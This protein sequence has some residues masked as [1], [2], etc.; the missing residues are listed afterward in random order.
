M[1]YIFL[2]CLYVFFRVLIN[3]KNDYFNKKKGWKCYDKGHDKIIYAEY[4]NG[5]WHSM[6][7][8]AQIT[9]GTFEPIF[10]ADWELYPDW[11]QNKELI[12]KR[13]TEKYPLK[14]NTSKF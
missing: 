4:I 7:I 8:E 3:Y 10:K 11:A 2:F 5:V 12:Q 14:T 13:V 6:V 9:V 1:I